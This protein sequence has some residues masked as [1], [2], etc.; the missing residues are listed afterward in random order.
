MAKLTVR[1]DGMSCVHCVRAVTTALS[2]VEGI[3]ALEVGIGGATIEHDGRVQL[4]AV[5]E[6]IA[7]SG[8]EVAG[9]TEDRRRLPVV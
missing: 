4:A 6:A 7:V 1:I 5:A 9:G 8:Y 2:A 3:I